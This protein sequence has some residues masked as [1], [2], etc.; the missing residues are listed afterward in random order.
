MREWER[1]W[2]RI[3]CTMYNAHVFI[4]NTVESYFWLYR[5]K[6]YRAR[7]DE[8]M[9]MRIGERTCEKYR[10][11][12]MIL[13]LEII[14]KSSY[15]WMPKLVYISLKTSIRANELQNIYFWNCRC[16]LCDR[17]QI[18]KMMCIAHSNRNRLIVK[19]PKM[20]QR[21]ITQKKKMC[22]TK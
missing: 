13:P 12:G 21:E 17:M 1:D 14:A 15:D 16:Q 22:S 7:E 19:S 2:V 11:K 10:K 20:R 5:D 6:V 9:S 4:N 8:R 3:H 18:D